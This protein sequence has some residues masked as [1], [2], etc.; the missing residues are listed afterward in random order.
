[1]DFFNHLLS[2][3]PSEDA[4]L[5]VDSFKEQQKRGVLLNPLKMS[6]EK[7]LS[8]F[9]N[10]EAHPCVKHAFIYNPNEYSLSK[11]IYYELGAYYLQEPSAMVPPSL[12][13]LQQSDIVLDLCSAPGGKT[14]HSS[15]LKSNQ[16]VIIAN[17]ISC[18]R[19]LKT[20]ENIEKLG[21]GNVIV[22][23]SDFTKIYDCFI[24]CFDKIILDAPCSGSGMFRKDQKFI[25]DWS[26][27]KVLKY[28]KEQKE[29]ITIAYK[30]LKPGGLLMYSTCSYSQEEDEDVIQ[31][32]LDNSDAVLA[33][34]TDHE[35]FYKNRKTPVG[36]HLFPHLFPGEG[37]YLCLIQKPD[38]DTAPKPRNFQPP[39]FENKLF[40]LLPFSTTY[41]NLEQ[42]GDYLYLFPRPFDTKKLNVL[43]K[44][45]KI[46]KI[47]NNQILRFDFHCSRF[48]DNFPHTI[49]LSLPEAEKYI[50]N[51]PI[52]A[53]VE[54]NIYW[55]KYDNLGLSLTKSDGH[56]L[57]NWYPKTPYPK[58]YN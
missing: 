56:L 51:H 31:F 29:L 16:G 47:I 7:F 14:I 1:M 2:Y 25:D 17:D 48:I 27:N 3:L 35:Y 21:I 49:D 20:I 50:N 38:S 22:T 4:K 8:L 45:V 30:M 24:N 46:G 55:L 19:C 13:S 32:L 37:H 23:C 52:A 40:K 43:Y 5:L 26:Y 10:V 12:L 41:T 34:I 53:T 42:I 11:S 54:K 33:H 28:Q 44:G 18:E 6:D 57:K 39:R 15:F 9:P 58:K 36:V